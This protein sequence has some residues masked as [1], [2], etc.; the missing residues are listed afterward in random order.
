MKKGA[1]PAG[2]APFGDAC[3]RLLGNHRDA[4]FGVHV[5]VQMQGN[6][7]FAGVADSAVRQAHFALVNA[8]AGSGNCVSDIACTYGTEQFAFVARFSGDNNSNTSQL[9]STSLGIG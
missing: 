3:A 5:T 4:D 6:G 9:G 8:D 2:P 7:V 1:G